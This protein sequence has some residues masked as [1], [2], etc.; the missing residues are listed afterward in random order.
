MVNEGRITLTCEVSWGWMEVYY[1][2]LGDV[3]ITSYTFKNKGQKA[4]VQM[5]V[6][7]GRRS[8]DEEE[9]IPDSGGRRKSLRK[10][11]G[12]ADTLDCPTCRGTGRIPRGQESQLVAVI[13][14]TDQRL[15]PRRTKLYV[16]LSVALC[17]LVSS[18][19]LFFLFPRSVLLSAVAVK[20]VYVFFTPSTV[21]MHI[22]NVLNITNNNFAVVDATDLSVQ[23]LFY[24]TV[25]GTAAIQ[26]V[27][28]V[29][30]RS[31]KAYTYEIPI[32]ISD[33]GLN[34]YCKSTSIRI[35]TLF[36]HLQMT[37]KVY[38]LSHS[39]QLSLDTFE[40]IDCGT[41]TTIPHFF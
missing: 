23:V 1:C 17:I 24:D 28:T 21:E 11:Q 31:A 3:V 4:C 38:Y 18:L 22:T 40:Y 34:A 13:P 6:S 5:G 39:E 37:M 25:L 26:N 12:A 14:C 35:H 30:P 33:E 41:N 8:E 36:L 32:E 16:C 7:L 29:Q 15:K 20:S 10:D 19:V 27:T 9:I 2:I